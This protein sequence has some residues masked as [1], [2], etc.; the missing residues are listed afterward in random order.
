MEKINKEKMWYDNAS[1]LT[2]IIIIFICFIILIS[3]AFAVNNNIGFINT[4]RSLF[5]HNSS[6]II[7]LIYFLL[8]KNQRFQKYFN[9]VNFLFILLY[10]LNS[11][12]AFLTIFQSF[13]IASLGSLFLN[14]ILLCY[15]IYTFMID[16]RLWKE[17]KLNKLPFDEFKNEWYYYSIN[18]ISFVVLFVNLI[19]AINFDG[20]VLSL[21]DTIYICLFARYIYLYK[22]YENKKKRKIK[23]DGK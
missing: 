16:T 6:Y 4:F 15:M 11:F 23:K 8:I 22:N 18:I 5:N 21:F 12:A 3:Q 19:A 13:G 7:A 9:I 20:V 17:F 2:T 10:F 14:V 1:L